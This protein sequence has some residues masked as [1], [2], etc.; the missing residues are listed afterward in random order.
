[1]KEPECEHKI[2]HLKKQLAALEA[3][4]A[5]YEGKKLLK[6][7]YQREIKKY[8]KHRN[9]LPPAHPGNGEKG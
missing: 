8:E 3:Q 6:E 9:Q 5:N 1:M 7:Y 4:P 2:N